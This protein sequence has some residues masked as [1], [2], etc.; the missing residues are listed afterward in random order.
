MRLVFC[1]GHFRNAL[2]KSNRSWV[3]PSTEILIKFFNAEVAIE[4]LKE[5]LMMFWRLKPLS[6]STVGTGMIKKSLS[7]FCYCRIHFLLADCKIS[8]ISAVSDGHGTLFN[9]LANK[10]NKVQITET[11]DSI[12]ALKSQ[13]T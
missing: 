4:F 8:H 11:N 12:I 7:C 3:G 13:S 1:P 5:V 9:K 6:Q 10:Y 2:W